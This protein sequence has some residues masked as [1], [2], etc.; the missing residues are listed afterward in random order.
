MNDMNK[1]ELND[2]FVDVFNLI[3]SK[4]EKIFDDTDYQ[5][6]TIKECHVLES[7]HLLK[8]KNENKMTFIAKKLQISVGALTTSIKTLMKKGYVERKVCSEDHRIIYIDLTS[9]GEEAN[10]LHLAFHD[11]LIDYIT[12]THSKEELNSLTMC[13]KTFAD[14]FKTI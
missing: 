13:L 14:F 2:F 1:Q 3:L 6:L 10:K 8:E 12:R 7:I 5:D 9:K 11:N 4:E